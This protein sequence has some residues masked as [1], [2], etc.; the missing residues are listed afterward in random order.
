[1]AWQEGCRSKNPF[2][3]VLWWRQPTAQFFCY[4]VVRRL[5]GSPIKFA[6]VR[7]GNQEEPGNFFSMNVLAT[8]Q[9]QDGIEYCI[10]MPFSEAFSDCI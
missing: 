5:N 7:T 8:V 3:M 4:D 2:A 6:M 10:F 1:V 9:V